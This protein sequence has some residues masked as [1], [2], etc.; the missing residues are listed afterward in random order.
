MGYRSYIDYYYNMPF[1]VKQAEFKF[2]YGSDIP[3]DVM[4]YIE[5]SDEVKYKPDDLAFNNPADSMRVGEYECHID[6]RKTGTDFK[7]VVEDTTKPEIKI[8]NCRTALEIA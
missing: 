1:A 7:I 5:I 2:E 3:T 4:N 8:K 6:W